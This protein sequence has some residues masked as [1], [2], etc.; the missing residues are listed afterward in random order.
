MAIELQDPRAA[1]AHMLRQF[2]A[3]WLV[4]FGGWAGVAAIGHGAA[5]RGL[6]LAALALTVGVPGLVRP[7]AIRP[8]FVAAMGLAQP[9]GWLVS[10]ALVAFL[11]YGIVTPLGVAFRALG[12]DTL[13]RRPHPADPSY[14]VPRAAP[15]DVRRYLRQF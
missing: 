9:I 6:A 14:W 4:I 3:L 5:A 13:G 1:T 2:A 11:F 15:V 7:E 12:R 8:L 10:Q